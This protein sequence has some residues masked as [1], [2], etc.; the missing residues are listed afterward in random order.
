MENQKRLDLALM[1]AFKGQIAL[2]KQKEEI[3]NHQI[4]I[5][6]AQKLDLQKNLTSNIKNMYPPQTMASPTKA[7][8]KTAVTPIKQVPIAKTSPDRSVQT[9][10]KKD[11]HYWS[12]KQEEVD[13]FFKPISIK[14]KDI[15][16]QMDG[17]SVKSYGAFSHS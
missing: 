16:S 14:K 13:E 9:P 2:Q 5:L 4:S 6:K 3:D 7:K 8:K 10:Q 11:E 17:G 1:A 12:H 15:R